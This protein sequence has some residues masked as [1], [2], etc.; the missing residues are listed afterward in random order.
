[1]TAD[2]GAIIERQ[3]L[4]IA[5]PGPVVIDIQALQ[6]PWTRDRGIGR[7]T[8]GLICGLERVA[9]DLVGSYLLN[10]ALP[11]I[12]PLEE[13]TASGKLVWRDDPG[14]VG[15]NARVLHLSSP[16]DPD[17]DLAGL[18]RATSTLR[19]SATVY[20]LIPAHNL[21]EALIDEVERRRY[22]TRLALVRNA[23]SVQVIS[24]RVA[25]EAH[26]LLGI[27]VA[28]IAQVGVGTDPRFRPARDRDATLAGIRTRYGGDGLRGPY[29][30]YPSGSH[31]RKHNEALVR[32]L[33][34][35]EAVR[36]GAV[37]A[38]IA[39]ALDGPTRH[40]LAVM[41][42]EAGIGDG[43]VTT[44]FV[45]DAEYLALVQAASLVCF[46]SLD[47]GYG[48]PIAEA[49]ACGIPVICS[50]RPPFDELV[51]AAQRFDPGNDGAI[52]AA[53]TAALASP[54]P[55][56]ASPL[57]TWDT[58]AERSAEA[59]E[60][61]AQPASPR[62]L[63]RRRE[64]LALVTPL[65]PSPTGV[66][67]YSKELARAIA[68][69]G[70][71]E[72]HLF[73]DGPTEGQV[74]PEGVGIHTPGALG[75]IEALEGPFDHVCYTLG[76]SHH[77]LGALQALRR[78]PGVVIA[79]D[80]RLTNLYRHLHG[81]PG[82]AP[83]G[84]GL[85]V[86]AMYGATLP[87]GIGDSGS[88]DAAD[89]EH[90]GVFM[91]REA[92]AA[93]T[94]F[95][96]SS[97]AAAEL[98]LGDAGAGLADRIEV[99]PFAFFGDDDARAFSE[100]DRPVPEGLGAVGRAWGVGPDVLGGATVLASFGIVDP[101][102]EPE[103]CLEALAQLSARDPD[104]VLGLVGPI[105]DELART[106]AVR[107]DVL[108]ISD[109]LVITGP[110]AEDAYRAWL[111]HTAVAIQ[112]RAATNGEA[113]AALGECLSAGLPTIVRDAGFFAELDAGAVV[114][115]DRHA[116]ASDLADLIAD[117]IA[118]PARRDQVGAAARSVAHQHTFDVTAQALLGILRR[119]NAAVAGRSLSA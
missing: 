82:V 49:L 42:A 29:L 114:H 117:L 11:P 61:L 27:D 35:V 62:I 53:I 73:A 44:G 63:R 71:V 116:D 24:A 3:P 36:S 5:G 1:V 70:T 99:L 74:G 72:V 48:L 25:D 107:A 4:G 103:L 41:A 23:Q 46:P 2:P 26:V 85:A 118:D 106:L 34:S 17:L 67:A 28:R 30:L 80:V 88:I 31:P 100:E 87:S 90:Y 113:S 37:Q 32:A 97:H 98:A 22:R 15:T 12:A 64:R 57:V 38:V 66:A 81:D 105:A 10:P 60:R 54:P 112:L 104:A 83:G 58:V 86:T 50:D 76:N 109:R 19:R 56:N 89:I 33:A 52:A 20:D 43:L 13:V 51:P 111:A 7:Y 108:G 79:H 84:L 39:G 94:A 69:D 18:P 101:V 96:V 92:I 45:A 55:V 95:L 21:S 59:L 93:S 102:K 77:H 119:T 16:L 47:E 40:H 115:L 91:A 68:A 110:L 14:A 9:P 65:P 78:R 75:A 6:A 8:A